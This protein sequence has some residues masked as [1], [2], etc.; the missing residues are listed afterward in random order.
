MIEMATKK[1]RR[2]FHRPPAQP[3]CDRAPPEVER[4]ILSRFLHAFNLIGARQNG[5]VN[6]LEFAVR[7]LLALALAVANAGGKAGNRDEDPARFPSHRCSQRGQRRR[8]RRCPRPAHPR[9][10]PHSRGDPK[11]ASAPPRLF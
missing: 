11:P 4:V 1:A 5:E 7:R 2:P 6:S 8:Q 3:E 10:Q 9:R